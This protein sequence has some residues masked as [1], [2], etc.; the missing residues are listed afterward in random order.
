MNQYNEQIKHLIICYENLVFDF[1]FENSMMNEKIKT[2]EKN[3]CPQF[4]DDGSHIKP[5]VYIG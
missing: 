1:Q 3:H 2:L 5:V 4:L